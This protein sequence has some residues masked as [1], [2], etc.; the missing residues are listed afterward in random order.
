MFHVDKVL[1][2]CTIQWVL[3]YHPVI[4]VL[5]ELIDFNYR[6]LDGDEIAAFAESLKENVMYRIISAAPLL[7]V[8]LFSIPVSGSMDEGT[9][10]KAEKLTRSQNAFATD[11]FAQ[12]HQEPGNLFFS[13]LSIATALSM[14]VVGAEGDTF[15]EMAKGLHLQDLG[16]GNQDVTL[17]LRNL[18]LE[19]Y[20]KQRKLFSEPL[21]GGLELHLANGLWVKANYPLNPQFTKAITDDFKGTLEPVDFSNE[22]AARKKINGWVSDQTKDKIRDL[23]GPNAITPA[24]RLVL[25]NAIYFKAA[26]ETQF[27]KGASRKEKFHISLD[28]D[29]EAEMM[30]QTHS[31]D[32]AELEGFK[33]LVMPYKG[34]DASMV[35]LLPDKVGGLADLE[36]SLS[37]EK[38]ASWLEKSKPER[39]ALSFPKFKNTSAINL[40]DTL[41]ALGMKKAFLVDEADFTGIAKVPGAPL[42]IGL[43][44][45]KAFVDVNEEGTEAA[46]S[47]AVEIR[48]GSAMRQAEPFPFVAD[49]PFIY[50]IRS[51]RTGAILFMGRLTDPTEHGE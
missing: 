46:A 25:A 11:L 37:A 13:P 17:T 30:K 1:P 29:V 3:T 10:N 35:V 16:S 14:T 15:K 24:T 18:V 12:L 42:Y 4:L 31:F 21:Q 33:L 28:K 19:A 32:L 43:V 51:N 5:A 41:I 48:A 44:I 26:W 50:I 49:H 38:L 22:P 9:Y 7:L 47:T 36:R 27:N 40:N 8:F 45:H 20:A 34:G 23:I 39:V 2:N 6:S